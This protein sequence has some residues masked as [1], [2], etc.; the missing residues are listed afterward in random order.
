MQTRERER[1][2]A[3]KGE[4]PTWQVTGTDRGNL[5]QSTIRVGAN[6][7]DISWIWGA[8][9]STL[10]PTFPLGPLSVVSLRGAADGSWRGV[11]WQPQ[12]GQAIFHPL[13][14]R[15][16][17][18]AVV[19]NTLKSYRD[20]VGILPLGA[21]LTL[22]PV[23]SWMGVTRINLGTAHTPNF[24]LVSID[25]MEE[26][27]QPQ[28]TIPLSAGDTF[29][30]AWSSDGVWSRKARFPGDVAHL[31][32]P[33]VFPRNRPPRPPTPP[34]RHDGGGS[35]QP[36][37]YNNNNQPQPQ[38]Q[39]RPLPRDPPPRPAEA[40]RDPRPQ[41]RGQPRPDTAPGA[42]NPRRQHAPSPGSESETSWPS[43][44]EIDFDNNILMQTGGRASSSTD[45]APR[46]DEGDFST[47]LDNL[48]KPLQALLQQSFQQP[49]GEVT[50][51]AYRACSRLA[52]LRRARAREEH[53]PHVDLT[54]PDQEELLLTNPL[55]EA[56]VILCQLV[57]HHNDMTTGQLRGALHPL[58]DILSQSRRLVDRL[59]TPPHPAQPSQAFATS[60]MRLMQRDS[61]WKREESP[62]PTWP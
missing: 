25:A 48:D 15:R 7:Q 55:A 60:R 2:A 23:G 13:R 33:S 43:D 5:M 26:K 29:W 56:Q 30:L 19:F 20:N 37:E 51:L 40:R 9:P 4:V 54:T 38:S 6:T 36:T 3:Q 53:A 59:G 1:E 39:P 21:K 62:Q 50:D 18:T 58:Q 45:P 24:W 17:P 34:H 14:Q 61:Q 47:L 10:P 27:E 57:L 22:A 46:T 11:V 41:Q 42:R 35:S 31:G 12:H 16:E 8:T 32:G 49:R 52:A 28:G 44:D